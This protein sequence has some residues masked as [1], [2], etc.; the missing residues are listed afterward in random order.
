MW[1]PPHKQRV[2][3]HPLGLPEACIASTFCTNQKPQ[4]MPDLVV[5]V[6]MLLWTKAIT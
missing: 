2:T 6:R 3:Y 5:C 4:V 1:Y